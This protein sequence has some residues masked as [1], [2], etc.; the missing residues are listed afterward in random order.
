MS[1]HLVAVNAEERLRQF[2]EEQGHEDIHATGEETEWAA[3][4]P[5]YKFGCELKSQWM[6]P[7]NNPIPP[8]KT[9]THYKEK[10]KKMNMP[11]ISYDIDGDGVV[12]SE[13]LFMAKRF[14]IDGNGVLDEEEQ[15]IG[16]QIIAEQVSQE[17]AKERKSERAVWTKGCL[18]SAKR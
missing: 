4:K 17:R 15:H 14:D 16:K 3:P 11:H 2:R 5:S 12:G 10:L 9:Q 13:D 8:S 7:T 6:D 1:D 18:L